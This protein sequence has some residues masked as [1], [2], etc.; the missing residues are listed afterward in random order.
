[1]HVAGSCDARRMRVLFATVVVVCPVLTNR[2]L[3]GF[4]H[5]LLSVMLFSLGLT[6]DAAAA[7][8]HGCPLLRSLPTGLD[9][10]SMTS[11]AMPSGAV[12]TEP[13]RARDLEAAPLSSDPPLKSAMTTHEAVVD[14]ET[15]PSDSE[16]SRVGSPPLGSPD[17]QRTSSGRTPPRSKTS[18]HL[19]HP[20]PSFINRQRL[21][22]RPRLLLQLQRVSAA[23]RPAPAFDVVPSTILPPSLARGLP[24][25]FRGKDRLGPDDLVVMT[26]EGY[27][28]RAPSPSMTAEVDDSSQGS[29]DTR[30]VVAT[31][32]QR[33]KDGGA[34]QGKAEICLAHGPMWEATPL[35]NGGY[36]LVAMDEHGLKTVARW[37]P[38]SPPMK[39]TMTTGSKTS[40]PSPG[41]DDR[42]FNFSLINPNSRRHP[43]IAS[44]TRSS[45]DVSD[46]YPTSAPPATPSPQ[47][48]ASTAPSQTSFFEPVPDSNLIQTDDRLRTLIL[49]TGIWVAFREGWSDSFH[50]HDPLAVSGSAA[51]TSA[52][53]AAI[54]MSKRSASSP[55]PASGQTTM[56]GPAGSP[57]PSKRNRPV[58]RTMS[59]MLHRPRQSVNGPISEN[60]PAPTHRRVRSTGSA[61]LSPADHDGPSNHD[62]LSSASKEGLSD[63]N[64]LGTG[65]GG[66]ASRA[67]Q[68]GAGQHGLAESTGSSIGISSTEGATSLTRAGNR[69]S[70]QDRN[71]HESPLRGSSARKQ[72]NKVKTL[73]HLN[74]HRDK[75]G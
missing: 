47:T 62:G 15:S 32:C 26:S 30:R 14:A 40:L 53:A 48:P 21:G 66:P 5:L 43:I 63:P 16:V 38:R 51:S 34:R 49:M 61:G 56:T 22:L 37:V 17:A 41:R 4:I 6:A 36:E 69:Y 73:F 55:G 23:S 9:P 2:F 1:M 20:P 28:S 71:R 42:R 68:G 72:W 45:I 27:S 75:D 31:I 46:A 13:A 39:R 67:S 29:S 65:M 24:S 44:M 25:S 35:T 12:D 52:P 18:F 7:H 58:S 33:R 11:A 10:S 57:D 8:D 50:Y 70:S 19:A 60:K 54:G 59:S 3:R 64:E 74:K